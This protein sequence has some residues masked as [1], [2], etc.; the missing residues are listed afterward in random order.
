MS[1]RLNGQCMCGAVTI[2]GTVVDQTP[3]GSGLGACHCGMCRK[4]T[5]SAFVEV[6]LAKDTLAV[7]G[8]VKTY[9]SSDWAERAFCS[10]CGSPLWYKLT[11]EGTENEPVQVS[12]GL[13]ENAADRELTL[14][15][16]IDRKPAG[17]AFAGERAQMTEAEIFAMYAPPEEGDAP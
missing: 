2:E 4:W 8:P 15:V 11:I 10:T 12:A 3:A 7:A 6:A 9:T 5:S 16:F 1:A 13:F 14:E 17:Y